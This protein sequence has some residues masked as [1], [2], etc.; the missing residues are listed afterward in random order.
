VGYC[1]QNEGVGGA[2]AM[3]PIGAAVR[4][5]AEQDAE[6]PAIT[7]VAYKGD[8][9]ERTISRSELEA[10]TNRLARTYERLGVTEG[11]FVTIG[12]PNGI[13]FYEASIAA[14][15]LGATPQPVSHRL[16]QRERDEIIML[17]KPSL[18]V[19]DVIPPDDDA[20]SEP[21]LPDR[22]APAFKAPTSGGST[23]R[24]KIIVSAQAGT[25]DPEVSRAFGSQ[26]NGVQLVPGPLYHN[27][28]FMFSVSGLLTGNHLVVM[29][30]FD[31]Q[32][33]VELVHRYRVD[34]MLLVPTMMLRMH[35]LPEDVKAR[36]DLS[37][38][39]GILHLAAP[40]P[41]WL[42]EAWIDWIGAEKVW[43]LYAGTE[44][45]G[46]TI[47]GGAD[48][49]AHRGTVGKPADGSMEI[50]DPET[51]TRLPVGEIGEVWMRPPP[52]A[53]YRYI[54]AEARRD[55][56][57]WESLGDMGSMDAEGY[58]YLADRR[59]DLILAGGAN[60]YPAEVEA[61]LDEHRGV[62]SCAVIGL[63]DE[64]LGQRV[65]AVIEL[66]NS[67]GGVTDDE[68]R[69]FLAE[70]LVGYKIPRSFERVDGQVRDDAGKVRRS[71]LR[72][73]R[74]RSET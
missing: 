39:N 14:W 66:D 54:G 49:I 10:R 51:G 65:H 29:P 19:T 63:P 48:W 74:I 8:G 17:V 26:A 31:A 72:A 21:I 27:A 37:S 40:C 12:L 57:G 73:E 13:A 58:L 33:A 53:T 4:W 1:L 46:V 18:V 28:P 67:N 50:R 38:V 23:G 34:W 15:K 30:R 36:N 44:A 43:E 22:T 59:A 11:S 16:P 56:T 61:A 35:R 25:I 41:P 3:M 2:M 60:I 52:D 47:I 64:D 45:Q 69:T 9:P 6:R 7:E 32:Q 5:L 68:L 62:R 70:R 24:P 55:D 42:K 20:S 71:G